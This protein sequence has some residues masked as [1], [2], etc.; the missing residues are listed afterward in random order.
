MGFVG[1]KP[2]PAFLPM[3]YSCDMHDRMCVEVMHAC[4]QLT[5]IVLWPFE[6]L[7]LSM[8]FVDLKQSKLN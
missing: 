3:T 4:I 8:S 2:H 6:E 7:V 5:R 1:R